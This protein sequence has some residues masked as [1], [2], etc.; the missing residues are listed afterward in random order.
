MGYYIDK[1]FLGEI[2]FDVILKEELINFVDIP[3][4]GKI[5]IYVYSAEGKHPHMHLVN[6]SIDF[7]ACLMLYEPKYFIHGNKIGTFNSKQLKV[8]NNFLSQ[9]YAN[10]PLTIWQSACMV[11]DFS[12][13]DHKFDY[14]KK[15]PDYTKTKDSIH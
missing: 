13:N 4:L 7:E 2:N 8:I 9:H 15:Q 10:S 11:W 5:K 3:K 14:Y 1:N 6:E 12:N